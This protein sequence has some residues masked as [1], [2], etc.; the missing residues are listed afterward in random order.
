MSRLLLVFAFRAAADDYIDLRKVSR[1]KD[2]VGEMN[3]E[4][5]REYLLDWEVESGRAGFETIVNYLCD[6]GLTGNGLIY[7]RDQEFVKVP[8]LSKFD[9]LDVPE[10]IVWEFFELLYNDPNNVGI[11]EALKKNMTAAEDPRQVAVLALAFVYFIGGIVRVNW[12]YP[13]S[14]DDNNLSNRFR[15]NGFYLALF[16]FGLP[17]ICIAFYFL[18]NGTESALQA[19]LH[20]VFAILILGNFVAVTDAAELVSTDILEHAHDDRIQDSMKNNWTNTAVISALMFSIVAGYGFPL[21]PE[22]RLREFPGGYIVDAKMGFQWNEIIQYMF[23]WC[24]VLS[25]VEYLISILL[26][27]MHLMWTDALSN[28]DM[29]QYHKDNPMAQAAPL[30]W[31][32]CAAFWHMMATFILYFYSHHE[33]GWTFALLC[34]LGLAYLLKELYGI[35]TWAPKSTKEVPDD[36][37]KAAAEQVQPEQTEPLDKPARPKQEQPALPGQFIEISQMP[38]DAA[39]VA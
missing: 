32:F 3:T 19:A 14:A 7:L 12:K 2:A 9:K 4:R 11:A 18:R 1:W 35:S 33:V 36:D 27:S 28:D 25:F 22:L 17:P 37:P 5:V 10:P 31:L 30:I 26:A 23:F 34:V 24:T 8:L 29:R 13:R 38:R 16:L 15:R 6:R 39:P 21:D 20:G